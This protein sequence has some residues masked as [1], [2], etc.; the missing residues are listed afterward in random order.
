MDQNPLSNSLLGP[1]NTTMAEDHGLGQIS[2]GGGSAINADQASNHASPSRR[3]LLSFGQ[4]PSSSSARRLVSSDFPDIPRWS[5]PAVFKA[6]CFEGSFEYQ[7]AQVIALQNA[8]NELAYLHN[9]QCKYCGGY[10]H[11]KTVCPTRRKIQVLKRSAAVVRNRL[12]AVQTELD[13]TQADHVIGRP[14]RLRNA[15]VISNLGSGS[16]ESAAAICGNKRR[17]HN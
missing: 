15:P 7:P 11:V 3:N 17:R 16:A 4:G 10:G 6:K 13:V 9:Q 8:W 14:P 5:L 1:T 2:A 12:A